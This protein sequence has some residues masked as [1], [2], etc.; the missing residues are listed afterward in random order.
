MS[1][2]FGTLELRAELFDI[3]RIFRYFVG[4]QKQDGNFFVVALAK[5]WIFVDIYFAEIRF[6]FRDERS[7]LLFHF[8]AKMASGAGIKR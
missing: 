5:D 7:N 4:S 6:E 2:L 1:R 3:H 8:A